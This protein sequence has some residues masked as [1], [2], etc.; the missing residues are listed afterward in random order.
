MTIGTAL[1]V[2]AA[3]YLLTISHGFRMVSL[4]IVA[5]AGGV[6][7]WAMMFGADKPQTIF[8]RNSDHPAFLMRA[9]DA[10]PPERHVWNGWCVK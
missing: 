4:G 6:L 3:V 8:Y 9:G 2:I 7:A 1:I 5:L 10:C